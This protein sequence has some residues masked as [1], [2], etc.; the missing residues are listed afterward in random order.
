[1]NHN[2]T[3]GSR[4]AA[5]LTLFLDAGLRLSELVNVKEADVHLDQHYVKVLG[6]GA[7]ER[8]VPIGAS[9]Q[10]A[11]LHY[12]HH[13]RGAPVHPGVESFFLLASRQ[14]EPQLATTSW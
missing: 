1:M 12:Y 6:K 4:N 5:M 9:C 11:L 14:N 2:T 10:K 3:I 8:M 7:K 13:F